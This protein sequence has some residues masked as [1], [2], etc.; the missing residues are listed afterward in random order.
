[1]FIRCG[2]I[3]QSQ[4]NGYTRYLFRPA[5]GSVTPP[6]K[7]GGRNPG[8]EYGTHTVTAVTQQRCR[9]TPKEVMPDFVV[10]PHN[11]RVRP[12]IIPDF[13][14]FPHR[15]KQKPVQE[16]ATPLCRAFFKTFRSIFLPPSAFR[17]RP[18]TYPR[19]NAGQPTRHLR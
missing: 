19:R 16:A 12:E 9:A 8:Q 3:K 10:F 15:Y 18:T 17:P 14:L 4:Q 11:K 6:R 7:S 5:S 2:P 13:I 1:M